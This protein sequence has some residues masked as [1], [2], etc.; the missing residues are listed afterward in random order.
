MTGIIEARSSAAPGRALPDGLAHL[1][2][3][4]PIDDEND[5]DSDTNSEEN[6]DSPFGFLLFLTAAFA[7]KPQ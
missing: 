7:A 1:E 4:D 3:D 5:D 2:A 6:H